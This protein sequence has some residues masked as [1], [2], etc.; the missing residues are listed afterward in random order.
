[1]ARW[2]RMVVTIGALMAS[3]T[4]CV[5]R[6]GYGYSQTSMAI[7][8]PQVAFTFSDGVAGYY[9]ATYNAYIYGDNGYYYRWAGTNWVYANDYGGPWQPVVTSVYLPPLLA[10]GPPPPVVAY[11][12][13][14]VWWRQHEARWYATRHPRWWYR[15]RMY[16][17]HYAL[18]HEH[19]VRFYARHPGQRPGMRP[20]FRTRESRF[21]RAPQRRRFYGP[22]RFP[23]Q[24]MRAYGR[25][26]PFR[27]RPHPPYFHPHPGPMRGGPGPRYFHPHLH[28]ARGRP[29]PGRS[30]HRRRGPNRR[31]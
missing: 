26:H 22:R 25:P 16:V 11:R 19:V 4:G 18:W 23:V 21:Y 3:L 24:R 27:G 15:H 6:A 12:P 20:L 28:P 31:P 9:D 17:R 5:A 30:P 1:M 8:G 2:V 7:G 14:F 13:Y 29:H 10:Y